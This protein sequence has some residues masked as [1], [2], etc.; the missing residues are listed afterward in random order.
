VARLGREPTLE[1]AAVEAD[2][3]RLRAWCD[4]EWYYVWME[5][6]ASVQGVE[7]AS[8]SLG[9]LESD[10]GEDHLNEIAEE[11]AEEARVAALAVRRRLC[12]SL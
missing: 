9:G 3:E 6:T 5:V 2:Y 7:F 10:A 11:V 1:E 8:A 12:A 4:S